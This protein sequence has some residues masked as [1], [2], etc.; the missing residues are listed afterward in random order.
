MRR[1]LSFLLF[2]AAAF[3]QC[4]PG[5]DPILGEVVACAS[6]TSLPTSDVPVSI[7]RF[8]GGPLSSAATNTAAF[9][10]AAAVNG[11]V[12]IPGAPNCINNPGSCSYVF[13]WPLV[14]P[15]NVTVYGDGPNNTV[16]FAAAS[17]ITAVDITGSN[18]NLVDVGVVCGGGAAI[19]IAITNGSGVLLRNA[20][21]IYCA[22]AG[23]AISGGNTDWVTVSNSYFGR[24]AGAGIT[25]ADANAVLL[26]DNTL[27]NDNG[28][29]GVD[30]SA[31]S[32][33]VNFACVSCTIQN[34]ADTDIVLGNGGNYLFDNAYFETGLSGGYLTAHAIDAG[35]ARS[36]HVTGATRFK[37]YQ[38]AIFASTAVTGLQVDGDTEFDVWA[39]GGTNYTVS[40]AGSGSTGVSIGPIVDDQGIGMNLGTV[41]NNYLGV[42]CV[43]FAPTNTQTLSW[44]TGSSCWAAASAGGST[45]TWPFVFRGLVQAGVTGFAASLPAASA[46]TAT[47]AGGTDPAPVLEWPTAQSTYYAWWNFELPTGYVSNAAI[48]YTIVSRSSDS[49]HAAIVTPYWSCTS[50]GALDAQTWTGITPVSIT[51][52]ATSG[53]VVTTGTITPTC[54]AGNQ[55]GVKLKIDT[56]TNGMTGPF[57]L[58]SATF[59]VQGG[60]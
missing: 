31:S 30:I 40:L 2:S 48:S 57:D 42:F 9:A 28:G 25:I 24:N 29:R 58:V 37:N 23:L 19:G 4:K 55:A 22:T 50:T 60:M 32:G 21:A 39:L 7:T 54:A 47:N 43:G 20:S 11:R 46:P 17:G 18:A 14:I 8:G 1:I 35:G 5:F 38:S 26:T 51:G 10:S 45:R 12:Y 41:V 15:A 49:T 34:D 53:R 13:T 6:V 36:V 27:I 33:G 56:N 44:N 3:G 16:L 52:A 59:S